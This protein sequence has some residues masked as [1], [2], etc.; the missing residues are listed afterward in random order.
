LSLLKFSSF[1]G[2]FSCQIRM[3][4]DLAKGVF[5]SQFRFSQAF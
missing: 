5:Y 2:T 4:P 1:T 3:N